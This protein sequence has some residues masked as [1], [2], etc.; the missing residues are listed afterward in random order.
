[1]QLRDP[2]SDLAAFTAARIAPGRAGGSLPTAP[3]LDFRLAHA[4]ARDA[5]L[6]P[7]DPGELARRCRE[8]FPDVIVAPSRAGDRGTFL[9]RPD[10]GR[11]LSDA[12]RE[13]LN[14]RASSPPPDLVIIVSDGLSTTAAMQQVVPT[15]VALLPFFLRDKWT[16]APLVIVPYGRVAIQDEVGGILNA[17]ISLMLLGER[18]G[19][20]SP[21]SLGAYFTYSP[22]PG[23]SD[24]DRNCISNIRPHGLPPEAAA[25]KLHALLTASRRLALSG[26]QLKDETSPALEPATSQALDLAS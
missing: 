24:A 8:I 10:L 4:R 16:L 9:Q 25:I 20:G 13:E 23:R 18:P 1:M 7:F 5:V 3:L 21:D 15:L 6:C 11:Q 17:K 26:V 22:M 14:R 12:S 2:W 19:L